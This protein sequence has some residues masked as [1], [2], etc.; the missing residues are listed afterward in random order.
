MKMVSSYK[1]INC[2]N[3]LECTFDL[4]KADVDVY[5]TLKKLGK[6]KVEELAQ[7]L[8][9]DRS[10]VYRSLQKLVSCE[11][12]VKETKTIKQG[13]YYHIYSCADIK[14]IKKKMKICIDE[15]YK[16]IENTLTNFEKEMK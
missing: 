10:T 7:K 2:N 1:D 5:R 14:Q 9:K 4:N 11:I 8:N 15:W 13:G 3:I 16:H 6:S 12:C